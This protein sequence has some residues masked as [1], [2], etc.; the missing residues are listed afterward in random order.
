M[1]I[2]GKG[3]EETNDTKKIPLNIRLS[4]DGHA[5]TQRLVKKL[6]GN[7]TSVIEMAIRRLAE[8]EGISL[9]RETAQV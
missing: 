6:G 3:M 5:L 8:Q 9:E 2:G 7:R 1:Y 4:I